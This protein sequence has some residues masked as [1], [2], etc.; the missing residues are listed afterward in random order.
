MYYGASYVQWLPYSKNPQGGG[1]RKQEWKT[2]NQNTK[3]QTKT[4]LY[5]HSYIKCKWS[6]YTN[7]KTKMG[8]LDEKHDPA[9]CC[10][11]EIHFKYNDKSRLKVKG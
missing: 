3:E 4:L 8:R 7:E 9:V 11:Q 5:N 2:E 6:K 10:L 1:R